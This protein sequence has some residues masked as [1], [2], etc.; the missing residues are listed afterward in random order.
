VN[1]GATLRYSGVIVIRGSGRLLIVTS[2]STKRRHSTQMCTQ[3][4]PHLPAKVVWATRK[5]S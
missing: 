2:H 5:R 1:A 3:V 4:G